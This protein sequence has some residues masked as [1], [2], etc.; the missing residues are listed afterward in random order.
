M[1]LTI[2]LTLK[3]PSTSKTTMGCGISKQHTTE[4][5]VP[6]AEVVAKATRK[7]G[8]SPTARPAK[9]RKM[10]NGQPEHY[11][12]MMAV[13]ANAKKINK[14]SISENS[15]FTRVTPRNTH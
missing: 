9:R 1:A 10:I 3:Q 4:V 11:D 15:A 12:A 7:L 13:I 6:P 2:I 8:I 5:D 14:L